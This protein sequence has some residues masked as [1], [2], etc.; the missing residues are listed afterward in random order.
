[1]WFKIS[2]YTQGDLSKSREITGK[3]STLL[4]QKL[5]FLLSIIEKKHFAEGKVPG[6]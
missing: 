4:L 3:Y 2:Q 1:M 6:R 5:K